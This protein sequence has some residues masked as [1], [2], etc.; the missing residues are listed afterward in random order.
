MAWSLRT[1]EIRRG[2]RRTGSAT[3]TFE[4]PRRRTDP[5]CRGHFEPAG[6]PAGGLN[7]SERPIMLCW[8]L[9]VTCKIFSDGADAFN[10]L[11]R[12][13][14]ASEER[15][16]TGCRFPAFTRELDPRTSGAEA[17]RRRSKWGTACTVLR[18]RSPTAAGLS[19][20][21][22]PASSSAHQLSESTAY[23]NPLYDC[24]RTDEP[25]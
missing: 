25:I 23:S 24:L 17:A 6:N 18:E 9:R 4:E 16:S 15:S 14:A 20:A 8:H 21:F 19:P 11:R 7:Y 2:R 5:F 22:T 1:V 10:L 12:G 3:A 13:S